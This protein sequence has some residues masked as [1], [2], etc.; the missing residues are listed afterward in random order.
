MKKIVVVGSFG[1]SSEQTKRL[2]A[3]GS[4]TTIES[5]DSAE[6]WLT[7]VEG[8]NAIISDGSFLLENLSRLKN[9]FVTYPFIELGA[10]DSAELAKNNVFV[11]NTKGSN[12]D[13]IVEW[14]MFMVLALLREFPAALN[15][16]KPW[17]FKRSQSLRD[18]K[19]LVVGA[20]NIGTQIGTVCKSFGMDV[21]YF[22][23]GDDLA[24]KSSAVDLVINA[25]NTNS[26]SK[27]LL[28]AEFFD[29]LQKGTYFV[30]FV[31]PYTYDID[32][33]IAAIDKGIVAGAAIDCDPESPGDVSNP[34][35]RKA[36]GQDKILVT[37]H[38][39][40]ATAQ[41]GENGTEAVVRNVEAFFDSQP[42]NV[43]TK[44]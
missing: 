25:L 32:G 27:N 2:E 18:K 35:Y 38:V 22:R 39:A 17:S 3:L 20:G 10:F 36:L 5:P 7:R 30:T 16:N 34:F 15:V 29:S 4:V 12:R 33:L 37:P 11:A 23:R 8:A 13:S 41:A 42:Q 9:V 6:E 19:V 44:T 40:F 21:D 31:R 14:V 43:L 24:A 28:S 26:S 1:F